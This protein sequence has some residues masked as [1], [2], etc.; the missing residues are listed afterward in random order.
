M[1]TGNRGVVG[2][3][4]VNCGLR[5]RFRIRFNINLKYDISDH[6]VAIL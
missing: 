2:G 4:G 3:L 5:W 1:G 6:R